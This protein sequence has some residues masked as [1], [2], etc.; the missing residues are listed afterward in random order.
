MSDLIPVACT[1]RN[2]CFIPYMGHKKTANNQ[3]VD[4]E[5]Y[6]LNPDEQRS[7]ARHR[8]YFAYVNKAWQSLPDKYLMDYPSSEHL[9]KRG[10]IECGYCTFN[11]FVASSKSEALRMLPFVKGLDQYALVILK[12]NVV[13]VYRAE[14]QTYR[15]M[16]KERFNQS[17]EDVENWIAGILAIANDAAEHG[18]TFKG[19]E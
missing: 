1:W 2:G 18:V 5:V 16:K 15:A 7:S 3:F 19:E 6:T 14:S 9:R 4:G 13:R 8:A 10:L 17:Q 12:D 11:D